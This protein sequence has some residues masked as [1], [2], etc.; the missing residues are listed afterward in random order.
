MAHKG[1]HD[2]TIIHIVGT[3]AAVLSTVALIP[4]L[5]QVLRSNDV[6]GLS[7]ETMYIMLFK[8]ILWFAYH[9]LTETYHGVVPSL[10]GI[11]VSAILIFLIIR[12][13]EKKSI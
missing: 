2:N 4:Q 5:A 12:K 11:A 13:R 8:S 7:I 1:E 6:S 3:S 10:V 9:F